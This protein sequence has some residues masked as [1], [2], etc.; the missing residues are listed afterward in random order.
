METEHNFKH[1][2]PKAPQSRLH[3]TNL[4]PFTRQQGGVL[5]SEVNSA[6]RELKF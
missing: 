6:R 5:Q 4:P 1:A 3:V 2:V